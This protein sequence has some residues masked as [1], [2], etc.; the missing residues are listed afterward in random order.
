MSL[1]NCLCILVAAVTPPPSARMHAPDR[2]R[3]V[4]GYHYRGGLYTTERGEVEKA[5]FIV[6]E[7]RVELDG[8]LGP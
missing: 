1:W 7:K 2:D 3:I 8:V 4:V 5:P 6:K